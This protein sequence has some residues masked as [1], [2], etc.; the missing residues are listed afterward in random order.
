M[1]KSILFAVAL[2]LFLQPSVNAQ[3]SLNV[4]SDFTKNAVI[5]NGVTFTKKSTLEEYEKVLGK[6]ERIEKYAGKDKFFAYDKLGIAFSLEIN[7]TT[8]QEIYITYI[9]DDDKKF[10]KGAFTGTLAING[11]TITT[12]TTHEEIGKL[13]G[14]ELV[15]VMKGF[16]IG[17]GK[18]LNLVAYYPESTLGQFALSFAELK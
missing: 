11:Q 16:Y 8:V 18:G 10:A 13:S 7:T 3:T 6:A 9:S 17:K 15:T 5:I 1:L 4:N 2:F 12:Q 14:A